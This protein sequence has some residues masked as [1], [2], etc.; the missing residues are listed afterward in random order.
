M[1]V[2]GRL[3]TIYTHTVDM[4]SMQLVQNLATATLCELRPAKLAAIIVQ[5]WCYMYISRI[6]CTWDYWTLFGDI[7]CIFVGSRVDLLYISPD[8]WLAGASVV[9]L[10]GS[11]SISRYMYRDDVL[12]WTI[13]PQYWSFIVGLNKLLNKQLRCRWF[14]T[15]WRSYNVTVMSSHDK[16]QPSESRRW[17]VQHK[18]NSSSRLGG[19]SSLH[20][21]G[22]IFKFISLNESCI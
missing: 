17:N 6:I 16:T 2:I 21:A 19:L 18:L 10:K 1:N 9:T 20:F 5:M 12:A 15:P 4:R 22:D 14:V 8:H 3:G 11:G 7:Y 13:F